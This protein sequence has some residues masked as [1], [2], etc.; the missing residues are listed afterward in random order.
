MNGSA[1]NQKP[2]NS[3]K[4]GRGRNVLRRYR[5]PI[6]GLFGLAAF[7]VVVLAG[8]YWNVRRGGRPIY[9]RP[10]NA[11]T[12]PVA[13]VFGAGYGKNGPSAMLYD[14]V[15][16]GAALYRL[17]KVR[18]LLMTGD[19]GRW[20]YNEPAIMR[21]TALRLGVPDRD[22]VLDF[23]GFRTY[24]SLY[25]AKAIFGVKQAILV[26]QAY[27]LPRALFT[28]RELGLEA[29]GV[30]ADS[31]PYPGQFWRN[32]R[33]IGSVENAWLATRVLHPRPTFLGRPEPIFPPAP[34]ATAL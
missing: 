4:P 32:V 24:D 7:V 33:E 18:K 11:P 26:T 1:D 5:R 23:A 15:A 29:V 3:G 21:K 20:N 27:H 28:A 13:V 19:N 6:L 16:T 9:T 25:R 17:G 30:A 31:G 10:E 34:N 2:A 22:I 8:I 14:R 12:L